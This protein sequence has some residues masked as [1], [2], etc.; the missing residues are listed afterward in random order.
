MN[1]LTLA[2]DNTANV[3]YLLTKAINEHTEHSARMIDS[4]DPDWS[5]I[6]YPR[7]EAL[8][9]MTEREFV[10]AVEWAD[11]VVFN[12]SV[13][14]TLM[15]KTSMSRM[16]NLHLEKFYGKRLIHH[17]HGSF[18]RQAHQH[19]RQLSRDLNITEIVSTPD[20]LP[21]IPNAVWIPNP[22]PLDD[23]AYDFRMPSLEAMKIVHSPTNR[24]IKSSDHF[25]KVMEN[26][27]D[28]YGVEYVPIIGKP[29]KDS[30]EARRECQFLFDQ[31]RLGS[32]GVSS[33]ETLAI[34]GIVFCGISPQQEYYDIMHPDCPI[35]DVNADNLEEK[36]EHWFGLAR[37][38]PQTVL[39]RIREG[40]AWVERHFDIEEI[41]HRF[42]AVYAGTGKGGLKDL[43]LPEETKRELRK[44]SFVE[45]N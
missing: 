7:H 45:K 23:P 44:T 11:V 15:V 30:M 12:S 2:Y 25:E 29:H 10:E 35:I 43:S 9:K 4:F 33:L 28:E 20:L 41:I 13:Y 3:P 34:G 19:I 32:Y 18:A 24:E 39:D 14:P 16:V 36:I 1:I 22:L 40:R 17:C 27:S 31:Y 8:E 6:H 21:L 5:Y 42:V 38:E 37:K 26:L